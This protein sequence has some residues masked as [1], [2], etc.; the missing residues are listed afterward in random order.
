MSGLDLFNQ[1]GFIMWPLLFFSVLAWSIG[2]YKIIH[3]LGF[4][5]EVKKLNTEVHNAIAANN[6][7]GMKGTLSNSNPLVA[8]PLE[9]LT[10]KASKE[11]MNERIGRR[12]AETNAEL[13]KH[14][15]VLGSISASAPFVGL[16]GTVVGIM[17]SFEAIGA[18]GKSGFSVV[19]AGIS[20]SLI[21]TAAGIIVAV[22][23]LLFYNYLQSRVNSSAQDFRI[24]MEELMDILTNKEV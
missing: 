1:G 17:D 3:V 2:V 19:A 23:A 6:L 14:L 21:A 9:V 18:S 10:S 7:A 15:W 16:F 4:A 22:V 8:R 12:L 11:V 13:K 5:K 20:E 24:K